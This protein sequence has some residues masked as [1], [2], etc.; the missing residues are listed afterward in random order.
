MCS[1]V[2][3]LFRGS[4]AAFHV[5]LEGAPCVLRRLLFSLYLLARTRGIRWGKPCP[6]AGV[7]GH[8]I[9]RFVNLNF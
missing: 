3:L 9:R 6:L 5:V 1:T 2:G 7:R 8:V 4:W